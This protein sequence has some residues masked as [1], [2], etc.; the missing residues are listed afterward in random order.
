MAGGAI[1]WFVGDFVY[2]KRHNPA[3]DKTP[4]ITGKILDHVRIGMAV[5][6]LPRSLPGNLCLAIDAHSGL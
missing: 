2:G 3:L 5:Q 4:T 1:G 6:P